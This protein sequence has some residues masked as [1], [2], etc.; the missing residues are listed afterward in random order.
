ML[1]AIYTESNSLDDTEKSVRKR[2][3]YIWI[4]ISLKAFD[5]HRMRSVGVMFKAQLMLLTWTQIFSGESPKTSTRAEPIGDVRGSLS[6]SP[7]HVNL[8]RK[9]RAY[10]KRFSKPG[11]SSSFLCISTPGRR[12]EVSR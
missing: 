5:A 11:T 2:E 4:S 7:Y 8:L 1:L 12:E 9:P 6:I 10:P 3:K